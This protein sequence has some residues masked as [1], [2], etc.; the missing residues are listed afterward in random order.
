MKNWDA[1]TYV[2][3][4]EFIDNSVA[5][6]EQDEKGKLKIKIWKDYDKKIFYYEDNAG[7]ISHFPSDTKQGKTKLTNSEQIQQIFTFFNSKASKGK[8]KYH[9][10]MKQAMYFFGNTCM[11]ESYFPNIKKSYEISA[12]IAGETNQKG[13]VELIIKESKFKSKGIKISITDFDEEQEF[14]FFDNNAFNDNLKWSLQEISNNILPLIAE[15]YKFIFYNIKGMQIEFGCTL[16]GKKYSKILTEKSIPQY[17][18]EFE[19]F[20]NKKYKK[21]HIETIN[22]IIDN[23]I[24]IKNAINSISK[25]Y[26]IEGQKNIKEKLFLNKLLKK[27]PMFH[28]INIGNGVVVRLG[29]MD[30]DINNYVTAQA[31]QG[32]TLFQDLRAITVRLHR[33]TSFLMKKI[34]RQF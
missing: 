12:S 32:L 15:K 23:N 3:L 1:D 7:G 24:R 4:S 13:D 5:K 31:H 26:L 21:N 30:P 8:N 6:F 19:E 25:N 14:R 29:I 9:V 28:V 2:M 27:E 22:N 16:K 17:C 20:K 10:G 34:Q 18:I 33:K 11:L